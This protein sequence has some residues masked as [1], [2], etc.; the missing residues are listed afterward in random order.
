[1]EE[2]WVVSAKRADFNGIADR[3][4]IDPVTTRLMRNRDLITDDQ[5]E[6]YLHPS[7]ADLHDPHQMTGG[8]EAA[9]I[10][11]DKIQ[12]GK[13]IRII[14]DYD[15]DG[16][17][18]TYILY[19]CL[20]YAGAQVDYE[21]P[22][23]MK[24]GFGLNRKL[25]ELAFDE[26]ADTILTCDNG[27]AAVEE[28]A[29]AKELGMTVIV[30][31]HHEPRYEETEQ[32]KR[33]MYPPADVIVDPAMP[34]NHYPYR[35]I[36]GAVVAWKVMYLLLEECSPSSSIRPDA[37]QFWQSFLPFAAFATVGDVMDLRN[38]NRS[39]V[40][41]GLRAMEETDNEGMI[42]L[43]EECGLRN[44]SLSAYHFGFILG[45]CINAGGR[46]DTAK[47]SLKLL[48]AEDPQEA[49]TLARELHRLNEQRKDLTEKGIEQACE[50]IDGGELHSDLVYVIYLPGCH[51]SIAGIIA[52]KV[53]ERYYRPVIIL[54]D[55]QESG[56][57]K[58]SGRSIETFPMYDALVKCDDLLEKYGGH[59]MAAGVTLRKENLENFRRRI[60]DTCSLTAE[61]LTRKVV[62]DMV[63]PLGYIREDLVDELS[64]LEPFGKGNEKPVFAERRLRMKSCDVIG[65]NRNV[66]RFTVQ[67][68]DGTRMKALYF[69]GADEMLRY[70]KMRFGESEVDKMRMGRPNRIVLSVLYY[71]SVNEWRGNTELQTCVS[72][73]GHG[74]DRH[75]GI[76][77]K[78][79]S[80]R[81]TAPTHK[82]TVAEIDRRYYD[83]NRATSLL[84]V[85]KH[86]LACIR[87][88][89][90]GIR[91]AK[92][93]DH[94]HD[95][96]GE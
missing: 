16:V 86:S 89:R 18:A 76:E 90:K 33:Y 82:L 20:Q 81:P 53:R 51:E 55:A 8:P 95:R 34:E 83:G 9:K 80:L 75:W 94:L 7:I 78:A 14:G 93:K 57:L 69:G 28:I 91:D 19:R 42:A 63:M 74:S 38:E 13:K 66:L 35:H 37:E 77:L 52:G 5:M 2:K 54:T 30:T 96:S 47:R 50:M 12:T 4:G 21:I 84:Y 39:I 72:L 29:F 46:L 58:G 40:S 17:N 25:I 10:L 88:E 61:D 45:P 41:L 32:G 27:I 70:L 65:K 24:D 79:A 36:C 1:M 62:I 23:R 15:I 49:Q 22:D 71:P 85:G 73:R 44:G 6:A 59:P 64:M 31:D 60:N 56:F 87:K 68:E 92:N 26:G 48:L 43:M 67:T 11:A 3:F